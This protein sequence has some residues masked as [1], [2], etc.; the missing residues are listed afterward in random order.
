MLLKT[1]IY[2]AS[3][4]IKCGTLSGV[5]YMAGHFTLEMNLSRCVT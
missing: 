2:N 5:N 4:E 3:T 1:P